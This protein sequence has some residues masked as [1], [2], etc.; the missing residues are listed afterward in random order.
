MKRNDYKGLIL[1]LISLFD[2]PVVAVPED[3]AGLEGIYARLP[4]RFPLLYEQL[5]LSYR[6]EDTDLIS[7]RLLANPGF[8]RLLSS[9][10]YDPYMSKV[11][12][13][14]GYIPFARAAGGRYDPI[15]FDLSVRKG[16][17]DCQIVWVE[18]EEVLCNSKIVIREIISPSF[19]DLVIHFV[20]GV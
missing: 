13:A 20:G 18:H 6:W 12:L 3:P 14:E 1:G 9:L 10:L 19:E 16:K 5:L 15:C 17:R 8:S 11:L 4:G 7:M 2:P